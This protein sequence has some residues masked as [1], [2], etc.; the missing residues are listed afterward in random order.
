MKWCVIATA[1][2]SGAGSKKTASKKEKEKQVRG[3]ASFLRLWREPETSV[4]PENSNVETF[5]NVE[6]LYFIEELNQQC[7]CGAPKRLL[8]VKPRAKY[9]Y[10]H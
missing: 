5:M 4:A 6:F 2:L 3:L 7:N 9:R 10:P 1:I 8:S